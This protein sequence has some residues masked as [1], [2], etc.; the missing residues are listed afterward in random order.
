MKSIALAPYSIR[1][2]EKYSQVEESVNNFGSSHDLLTFFES[3]IKHLK[4]TGEDD[5]T[6][7][8][9]LGVERVHL[10]G[11]TLSGVIEVGEYGS[12]SDIKDVLAKTTVWKKKT[13]HAD[14]LGFYFLIS[15][16]ANRTKGVLLLQKSGV[17]G[18]FTAIE[19]LFIRKMREFHDE[20]LIEFAALSSQGAFDDLVQ[21]GELRKIRF[22]QYHVPSDIADKYQMGHDEL[23]GSSEIVIRLRNTHGMPYRDQIKEFF[24]GKRALREIVEIKDLSFEPET[25]KFELSIDGK[26]R[27]IGMSNPGDMRGEYDITNDV[28]IGRD[29]K[30]R[31]ES[32]DA[33]ARDLLNS[34]EVSMYGPGGA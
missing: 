8:K 11:R 31:F 4:S 34:L 16:P 9:F 17:H 28:K 15:L 22:I 19:R 14:M 27:T 6:T 13:H 18:T 29:G 24:K 30:P 10:I 26:R 5:D 1:V 20:Y 23:K 2:R 7:K 3:V 25:I 33:V 12:E 21:R 32:I